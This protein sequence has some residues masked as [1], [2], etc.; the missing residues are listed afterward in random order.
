MVRLPPTPNATSSPGGEDRQ[1]QDPIGLRRSAANRHLAIQYRD[2]RG[3]KSEGRL[4]A[5]W[6]RD[7]CRCRWCRRP[8]TNERLLDSTSLGGSLTLISVSPLQP[9]SLDQW[10]SLSFSDGH[11]ARFQLEELLVAAGC[12]STGS[13]PL[14]RDRVSATSTLL[15]VD[16]GQIDECLAGILDAVWSDGLA[17][18][19][20]VEP[21]EAGLL[22][23]A[24][25]IGPVMATNY[26]TTWS[27]Q[28][29][30]PPDGGP[31]SQVES[32][33]AL[34]VHA[35]LPYRAN[36]PGIQL[37]LGVSAASRGGASTFVDAYTMAER[38]RVTDRR[39]WEL[40]TT[41]PF[42]YP[43]IRPGV[44]LIGGGPMIGLDVHGRYGVVRRAPDLVGSPRVSSEDTPDL[45]RAMSLWQDLVDNPANQIQ[46]KL[47]RGDLVMFD[48]HRLLHGR[49]AFRLEPGERRWLMGCYLDMDELHNRRAVLAADRET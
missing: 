10:I 1:L 11:N 2:S 42:T 48:N 26:G 44:K 6:L 27:F 13:G 33:D 21:T 22:A 12:D 8:S 14:D 23:V 30:V 39:A 25:R 41:V 46:V 29:E 20:G 9:V 32:R 4:H 19:R 15:E 17:M 43:Y 37:N 24:E 7:S 18:I 40:L 49:T 16:V 38:V 28:A 36:P 3:R 45:Y 5:L 34:R 47:E 35:D 31:M